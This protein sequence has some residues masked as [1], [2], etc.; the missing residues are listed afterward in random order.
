MEN[1]KLSP[2]ELDDEEAEREAFEAIQKKREEALDKLHRANEELGL[3][4]DDY[5]LRLIKK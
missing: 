4:Y 3:S 2:K 5:C 1:Q